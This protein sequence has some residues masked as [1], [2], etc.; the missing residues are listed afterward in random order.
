MRELAGL[1][2]WPSA[3]GDEF[4]SA[5]NVEKMA[6]GRPLTDDDRGPWLAA[7]AAW[8]G[9][10]ERAGESC[11]V[12]CSALKRAYR[13]LLRDGHPSVTFV[14]LTV[15][16]P[17]LADRLAH[18]TGHFMPVSLLESQVADLEPLAAEELGL[19]VSGLGEPADV[20]GGV[21]AYFGPG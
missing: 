8:I 3:E 17:V 10:R 6:S 11:V 12:A 9:E 1:L 16:V 20:A 2:G 15:P 21:A 13:D 7:I 5:A 4:H 14:H 18:R 19:V